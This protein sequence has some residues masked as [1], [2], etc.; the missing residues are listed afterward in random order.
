MTRRRL[1][2]GDVLAVAAALALLLV[3]AMDWYSTKTGEEAR[4]VEG[5]SQPQGALGGEVERTVKQRAS[6]AAEGQ[7][8]NAWQADAAI[9]RVILLALLGAAGLAIAAAA[10]RAAGRRF[11]PP[12]TPSALAAVA[13]LIAAALVGYR[14]VQQP[15]LD[16]AS[17]IKSGAPL[18]LVALGLLA[19]G[20]ARALKAEETGDAWRAP[21]PAAGSTEPPPAEHAT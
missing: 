20:A 12:L 16:V 18:A 8:Q 19:L 21:A 10:F 14:I 11:E 2:Y 3:M 17:T 6:E 1:T 4:R 15:G 7:E 9:D 5:L 13:A